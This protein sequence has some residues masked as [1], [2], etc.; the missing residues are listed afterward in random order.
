T[1]TNSTVRGNNASGGAGGLRANGASGI[2]LTNST[3]S[4]NS[5]GATGGG[6]STSNNITLTNSTVSGNSAGTIGGGLNANTNITLTNSIVANNTDNG[7]APDLFANLGTITATNSLIE[8]ST[9]ATITGS[10]NIIGVDPQLLPLGDYGGPTQTHALALTSPALN[11]G[12]NALVGS[13][14]T[15]QRGAPGARIADG[16]V[17]MGAFEWQGFE[18]VPIGN[19]NITISSLPSTLDVSVKVVEKAFNIIPSV[20]ATVNFSPVGDVTGS[21]SNG[22]SAI[23]DANGI[24]LNFFNLTAATGDFQVLAASSGLDTL[25]FNITNNL[26]TTTATTA[27][28]TT[29]TTTA[30]T[31]FSP[32][33]QEFDSL[34]IREE[35]ILFARGCLS[36][37]EDELTQ[38]EN[39]TSEEG[40]DE[41]IVAGEE[42]E[43]SSPGSDRACRPIDSDDSE[44]GGEE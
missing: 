24:A 43:D 44:G 33:E 42:N 16:T 41:E 11:A 40:E 6:L 21:F 20:G 19:Q 10:N 36:T 13:L 22:T 8:D 39:K 4:G 23:T 31:D 38:Q 28:T 35:D 5:A 1:V 27:T 7:T 30:T 12:D 26:S 14:T 37:P 9:G 2:T 32:F 3:V 25:T 34:E 15:D 18:I 29:A 17:D